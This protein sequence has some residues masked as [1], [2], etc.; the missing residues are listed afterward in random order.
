MFAKYE[1]ENALRRS[2]F[3]QVQELKGN[4]RVYCRV[5]P[6]SSA[7]TEE[8]AGGWTIRN[9]LPRDMEPL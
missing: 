9:N 6:F 8:G 2:L 3:N 7:E 4:I 1:T 5:R